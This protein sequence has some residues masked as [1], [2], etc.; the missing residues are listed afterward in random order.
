MKSSGV[1]ILKETCATHR[2]GAE[3]AEA[4][5]RQRLGGDGVLGG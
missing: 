2:H 5:I 3:S 4:E 1:R